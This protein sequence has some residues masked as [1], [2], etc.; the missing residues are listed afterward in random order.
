MFSRFHLLVLFLVLPLQ[1]ARSADEGASDFPNVVFLLVDDLGW[2]DVG[3]NGSSLHRTPHI[4]ALADTG[5]RFTNAYAA[6]S[7]CSPTRASLMT[8]KHPVRVNITD[9]IPGQRRDNVKLETPEDQHFLGLEETTIA[10]AFGEGGYRTFFAGKWHLGGDAYAPDKQGFD[11]YF[12][13]HQNPAVGSPRR[14]NADVDLGRPHATRELTD[15]AIEFLGDST[16]TSPAFVYLS[17]FDVHTPIIPQQE[18]LP[19]YQQ[20]VADLPEKE[21]IPEHYGVSRPQQD[22][23]EYAT[24]VETVDRSVGRMLASLAELG[25]ADNTIMVFFSDNGGLCTKRNVGPTSNL[26]LRSGKGWLYEGGIRVPCIIKLPGSE[27][28][29]TTIDTPIVSMDFYPTLLSLAGLPARPQQ[30]VDGVDLA[31][32][33]KQSEAPLRETLYWHYP[34]YH[35]SEWRPGAAIRHNDWKLIEFYETGNVELYNLADDPGEQNDLSKQQP[36]RTRTVQ[37]LLHDWQMQIGAKLPTAK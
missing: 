14:S 25:L 17:Y 22:N 33:L 8:G 30:T 19:Y 2:A 11:V 35:G 6:A 37:S 23:P 5:I 3:C 24:M 15:A 20:R 4:D 29:G 21:P 31:P 34:H 32:L 9:W 28:A 36:E 13:P 16:A 10:E 26:P 1:A 18:M 27:R 12:D 7:I